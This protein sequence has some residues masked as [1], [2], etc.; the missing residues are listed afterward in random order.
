MD[1]SKTSSV[2]SIV[3]AATPIRYSPQSTFRIEKFNIKFPHNRKEMGILEETIYLLRRHFLNRHLFSDA[4]WDKFRNEFSQY[5]DPQAAVAQLMDKLDDPYTRFIPEQIMSERQNVIRGEIGSVGI[6]LNRIWTWQV[7]KEVIKRPLNVLKCAAASTCSKFSASLNQPLMHAAHTTSV[8]T[9]P[10]WA[11]VSFKSPKFWDT[12]GFTLDTICPL[13]VSSIIQ[14]KSST[15]FPMKRFIGAACLFSVLLST[16]RRTLP[17]IRP[18]QVTGLS[19]NASKAG[20]QLGDLLL[21]VDDLRILN[22]SKRKLK[23]MLDEG[24]EIGDMV[25]LGVMRA[26]LGK[27]SGEVQA[28]KNSRLAKP[29][30]V[31]E[32]DRFP[33]LLEVNI[34]RDAALLPKVKASLLPLSQ[35]P[36]VGYVAIEEFTDNTYFEVKHAIS[37]IQQSILQNQARQMEALVI[38]LRGN[39]G[40]PM[41]SALDVASMFLPRGSVLT[42]TLIRGSRE[43]HTSLNN[44]VDRKTALLLLIDSSTASASEIL[45]ASLCENKRAD[46]MGRT[47]VGKNLAQ[48]IMMLSDGSGLCFTVAEYLT[49]KGQ[50]MS[51]GFKPR[52]VIYEKDLRRVVDRIKWDGHEFNV[53]EGIVQS[54]AGEPKKQTVPRTFGLSHMAT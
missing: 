45:V 49:P 19:D 24:G 21:S 30:A 38:D 18:Y 34:T 2:S 1:I 42:Q 47:T 17:I 48:A 16:T 12:L 32:D 41:A 5:D 40:G 9:D 43:K 36:G 22:K 23:K 28:R 20:L 14:F 8:S 51:A 31:L 35:G 50:S 29:A 52:R 37:E 39:P 13:L 44:E 46:S 33:K 10:G 7:L 54:V 11:K 3:A 27:V 53:P 15:V 26:R 25:K 4:A 6:E